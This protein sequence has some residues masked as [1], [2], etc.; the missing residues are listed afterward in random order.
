MGTVEKKMETTI[1]SYTGGE[2]L[3]RG[4]SGIGSGSCG[5]VLGVGFQGF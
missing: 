5:H 2:G 1:L 4:A 3:G